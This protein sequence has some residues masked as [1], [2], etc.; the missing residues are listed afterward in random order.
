M[1]GLLSAPSGMALQQAKLPTITLE[2]L[3]V[4]YTSLN[5]TM[6]ASDDTVEL[7]CTVLN[8]ERLGELAQ[9]DVLKPAGLVEGSQLISSKPSTLNSQSS[10]LNP[11]PYTANPK[12]QT[13]NAGVYSI[14]ID[15]TD[16]GGLKTVSIDSFVVYNG[17]APKVDSPPPS[18]SILLHRS[19]TFL[20]PH[21]SIVR[22]S[23]IFLHP[24]PSILNLPPPSSINPPPSSTLL[25][26]SSTF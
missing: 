16:S 14:R 23:S 21:P 13:P 22:L 17:L 19:S 10:T 7:A 8:V 18:S 3:S 4:D 5:V 9:L 1:P 6:V 2:K 25:H 24:P 11:N 12:S 15:V 26:R 20:H